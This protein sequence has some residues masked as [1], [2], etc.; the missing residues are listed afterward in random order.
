MSETTCE[1]NLLFE[2]RL[3]ADT[4]AL[5]ADVALFCDEFDLSVEE[6][7]TEVP[8]FRLFRAG[9]FQIL[10]AGCAEPLDVTHFLDAARPP[11]APVPDSTVLARLTAHRF[12]L[13]VLVGTSQEAEAADADL[14]E[15]L[16]LRLTEGLRA[17]FDAPLVF[18]C[19][20]D[21]LYAGEEFA[22]ADLVTL[23]AVPDSELAVHRL[24]QQALLAAKAMT[25][26]QMQIV[27]GAHKPV[28]SQSRQLSR[29]I[30]AMGAE[31][32]DI[33]RRYSRRLVMG[34]ST[35]FGTKA[36]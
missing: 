15:T 28:R 26:M 7:P 4:M 9:A 19:G 33:A 13:T 27:Q 23:R 10:V 34:V 35:A 6:V 16:C 30:K 25:Y 11:G 32:L 20:N 24:D 3:D 12:S 29:R 1:A 14:S 17:R 8:A 2:Q 22:Q 21:T 36:T 31:P 18:W 5:E